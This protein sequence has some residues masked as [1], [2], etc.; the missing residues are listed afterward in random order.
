M[1]PDYLDDYI[2]E[3]NPIRV[4]DAFVDSLD[5]ISLG[6]L[7]SEPSDTGRPGYNPSDLLK[8][9]IY[10]YMNRVRSSRRL[11][12]ETRRNLE[13]LWLIREMKPDYRTIARF[14]Q[15]NP[16]ALKKVFREF[17]RLCLKLN[18]YGRE[19]AAIDGSKFRAVNSKDRNFNEA[20]L[21]DRIKRLDARIAEYM[22]QLEEA[23]AH[24]ERGDRKT[25]EEIRE[26]ITELEAR[27]ASYTSY[28]EELRETGE[29]QKSLTDPDARRM[30]DNGS[31]EVCY[32]A[33]IAVDSKHH[34]IATY[35][36]TNGGNDVGM[37]SSM[38][39]IAAEVLE[40]PELT[41]VA[42]KGYDSGTGIAECLMEG[43]NPQVAGEDKDLCIP[44]TPSEGEVLP[45]ITEHTNG[46][47]V[48]LR[49]RNV[50]ICPLGRI[51]Y[52]KHY[53]KSKGSAVFNN[54][55]A[56]ATC[57]QR[58]TKEKYMRFDVRMLKAKFRKTYDDTE[59]HIR[60]VRYSVDNEIIKQ[61][62]TIVEHPFGTIKR[63]MDASYLLTVGLE[64]VKAELA[65][66]F[67][68]YNIKR[69]INVLGIGRLMD[70]LF[71]FNCKKPALL[72]A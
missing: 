29:T 47:C 30:F 3:D 15:E 56:C 22:S 70:A 13:V 23:D 59:L 50:V 1:L 63:S 54:P 71:S 61:R 34:L 41:V 25:A 66:T 37:L 35:D 16:E 36:V 7:R 10:G 32:N 60:Q 12:A 43:I 2:D 21:N 51:L 65:L 42:D 57:P 62:K 26:I 31:T 8:L 53:K 64:S 14:R 17:S 11:E 24:E 52:P 6:F 5:L 18:L 28:Q 44:V 33:Q 55:K 72:A 9:M 39:S 48:Y 49:E 40:N 27:K 20:K 68:A 69:A 45:E 4:V 38:A 58:C 67:L 19:L 46:R